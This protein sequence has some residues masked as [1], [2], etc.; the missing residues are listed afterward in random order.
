MTFRTRDHAD[1]EEQGSFVSFAIGSWAEE[2]FLAVCDNT[3]Y[4]LIKGLKMCCVCL[5]A[6][7]NS[8][9]ALFAVNEIRR[10][11]TSLSNTLT[12]SL[13]GVLINACAS[14]KYCTSL[15]L[16]FQVYLHICQEI[17]TKKRTPWVGFEPTTSRSLRESL[18]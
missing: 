10:C 5:F 15:C 4:R 9:V 2:K 13:R 18:K 16:F 1:L 14:M 8:A 12:T 3:I 7:W 6:L 17:Q 11:F